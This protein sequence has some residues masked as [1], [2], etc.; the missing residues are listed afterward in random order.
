MSTRSAGSD[1]WF[2]SADWDQAARADFEARLARL[3]PHS[4]HQYRRIK[5]IALLRS[6]DHVR[7]EVGA[8]LLH[9]NLA[10]PDLPDS[11]RV[12]ALVL[13]AE[14]DQRR[15][16]LAEAES[17]LRQA[18]AIAG[19][20]GSGTSGEEEIAL[21]EILVARGGEAS[22]EEAK[23]LLDR[24]ASEVPLF[25]RSRYRLAVASARVS[26][27]LRQPADAAQW[28]AVALDLAATRDSGLVRHPALGLVTSTD[29]ELRWL[30]D[31]AMGG[32]T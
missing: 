19:P 6:G 11:E 21:A 18:L 5:A 1:E 12:L 20:N 30:R 2:R 17:S 24:R 22:L 4:R 14:H 8:S 28:A 9:E 23:R 31:V 29:S 15:G 3:R 10:L 27:A 16:R 7:A 13:L 25:V 32:A 26:L